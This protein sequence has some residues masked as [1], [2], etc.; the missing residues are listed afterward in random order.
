VPQSLA[1]ILLH[2]IFSTKDR[3]RLIPA[4]ATSDLYEYLA[5]ISRAYACPAHEIGGTENHVHICCSLARTQTCARLIEEMKKGSSKWMKAGAR[6][7][8][9]FA[10]QNGYGAFSTG[11]G[12]LSAVKEYIRRQ[13]AHHAA[14]SFED[15]LRELLR[16]HGITYDER[17]LWD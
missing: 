11:D 15:E 2:I 6:L 8:A 1:N 10:W 12:Q 17:Y 3:A 14:V 4:E 16:Q 5:A 9:E 13:P 7:V